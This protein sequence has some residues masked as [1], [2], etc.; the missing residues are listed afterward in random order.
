MQQARGAGL[1]AVH[2]LLH[3]LAEVQGLCI[4]GQGVGTPALPGKLAGQKHGVCLCPGGA[5]G[6]V[7][8]PMWKKPSSVNRP[9]SCASWPVVR[10]PVR[11]Q[12]PEKPASIAPRITSTTA[13]CNQVR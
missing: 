2:A 12:S 6:R 4:F 1:Q 9:R 10:T 13:P 5:S 11:D 8:A 3:V 7:A